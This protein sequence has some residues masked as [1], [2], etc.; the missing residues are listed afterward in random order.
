MVLLLVHCNLCLPGS[1]HFLR[2]SLLSSWDYR[3]ASPCPANF[4]I[5]SRDGVSPC[6][7]V[8]SRTL[9]SSDPPAS[10][11][12]SSGITATQEAEQE[13][14]GTVEAEVAV[15]QDPSLHCSLQTDPWKQ[16][17]LF[18]LEMRKPA[19]IGQRQGLTLLPRL[20][21]SHNRGTIVAHC[22][23]QLL[24]SS[25]PPALSLFPVFTHL[26]PQA[27]TTTPCCFFCILLEMEF[28]HV[29]QAG[30]KLLSS[31]DLPTSASQSVGI[32]TVSH[33][34]QPVFF[35]FN[36][37]MLECN[38]AIM[39]QRNHGSLQPLPPGFKRFFYLNIPSSRDYK[40]VPPCPTNFV[41]LVETGFLRLG[42]ADLELPTSGDPPT[43]ASQSV[44]ITGMSH[45]VHMDGLTL[46]SERTRHSRGDCSEL[47]L[48]HCTPAWTTQQDSVSKK[49]KKKKLWS[50]VPSKS[51]AEDE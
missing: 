40:H 46:C 44:G 14:A 26:G 17:L 9:T 47:K 48:H 16:T 41:F 4:C 45:R 7:P 25:S 1:S 38:G 20:Q 2:L 49:K 13:T 11:S 6:W 19:R 24:S 36:M 28:H 39:A 51:G 35:F 33:R 34:A 27:C 32:T 31:G 5:F 42:Q 21:C 30:L 43:S 22:S 10:A 23:L 37:L 29:A 3:H 12:Q 18:P 15:N 8:W 50:A